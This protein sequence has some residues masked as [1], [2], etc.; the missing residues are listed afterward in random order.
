MLKYVR[1]I[2]D[3]GLLFKEINRGLYGIVHADK[4]SDVRGLFSGYALNLVNAAKNLETRKQKILVLSSNASKYLS[5]G[6]ATKETIY[7]RA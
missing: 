7:L 1:D 5:L 3:L 6:V 2:Q 4:P